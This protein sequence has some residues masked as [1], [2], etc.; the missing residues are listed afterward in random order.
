MKLRQKNVVESLFLS[1]CWISV[2][3]LSLGLGGC[4][5]FMQKIP[6]AEH[7]SHA[8]G[9]RT[10]TQVGVVEYDF[11]TV[12][13]GDTVHSVAVKFNVTQKDLVRANKFSKPY[14]LKVG[15]HIKIPV[16][17]S[18]VKAERAAQQAEQAAQTMQALQSQQPENVRLTDHS[19]LWPAEG[20]IV[21]TFALSE[22]GS[23]G[24]DIA[25]SLGQTIVASSSGKV[26]YSGSNLTGYGKS[27]IIK[28]G[29][30]VVTVYALAKQVLVKEG[31]IVRAGEKVATMGS[32]ARGDVVL[33]FEVRIDGAPQDPLLYLEK[34]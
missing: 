28:H 6:G 18:V 1:W 19:L 34:K 22:N 30:S 25:G 32:N 9:K 10:A 7:A 14:T 4:A 3:V 2:A 33:H 27:I 26:V 20:K 5:D 24:I 11:Y 13:P 31:Q 12:R 15:Q 29:E 21:R 17:Q 23:K 16:P 8:A